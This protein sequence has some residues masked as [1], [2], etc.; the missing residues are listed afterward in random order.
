MFKSET[1]SLH[2]FSPK[3]SKSLKIL[4]IWLWVVGA[5]RRL[6]GISK[7]KRRTDRLTD[8]RTSQLIES[9]SPE[10]R[11]FEKV[12]TKLF[13]KCGLRI[14]RK[15]PNLAI[16]VLWK[17]IVFLKANFT[18]AL[19]WCLIFNSFLVVNLWDLHRKR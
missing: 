16:N 9:I 2:Y 5:K 1:T 6:N 8:R 7:V 10:G 17:K 19:N 14:L 4:D 18:L 11:C 3:Y 12:G 13:W 15:M